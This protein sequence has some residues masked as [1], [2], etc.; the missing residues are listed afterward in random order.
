MIKNPKKTKTDS[1]LVLIAKFKSRKGLKKSDRYF[2]LSLI[3]LCLFIINFYKP[4]LFEVINNNISKKILPIKNFANNIIEIPR[5]L[6]EYM[7][8]KEENK[9]LRM[10]LDDLKMKTISAKEIEL[11][12]NNLKK[13]IKMKYS[14]SNVGAVEKVMGF[15][16]GIYDSYLLI[17]ATQKETKR[18]GVVISSDGLVGVVHDVYDGI[19]RVMTIND[20]KM[21]IPV[22]S[23]SKE[24]LIM[25]GMGNEGLISKEIKESSEY[26]KIQIK[27]GDV[28]Y[29]S[30]EGGVFMANI[31]VCQ[32]ED[33]GD[34]KVTATPFVDLKTLS[35]VWISNPVIKQIGDD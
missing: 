10:E 25:N 6:S 21:Y 3:F 7:H 33:I 32:V 2:F 27:K 19:A 17:T 16:K 11:E 24:H 22:R 20:Q 13:S 4:S 1:F 12:L 15:D 14:I 29:T 18:G 26:K 30:G 23:S 8:I 34:E 9:K 5:L 35:F 31:P 28:L